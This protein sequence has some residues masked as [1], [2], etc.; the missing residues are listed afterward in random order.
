MTPIENLIEILTRN[1][2]EIRSIRRE[3]QDDIK[4]LQNEYYDWDLS[5]IESAIFHVE[6]T[7]WAI[8]STIKELQESDII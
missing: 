5:S 3:L 7:E 2:D 6:D 8:E 4:M 1:F